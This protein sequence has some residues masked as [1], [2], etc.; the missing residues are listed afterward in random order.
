MDNEAG[1]SLLK[2][3]ETLR[4]DVQALKMRADASDKLTE[5]IQKELADLSKIVDTLHQA[6]NAITL[7]EIDF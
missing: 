5:D 6:L 4:M 7:S 3:S 2:S 1:I